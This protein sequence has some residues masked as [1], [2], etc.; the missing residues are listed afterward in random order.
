VTAD[1]LSGDPLAVALAL[2]EIG[3][4]VLP[5]HTPLPD[6]PCTC[7]RG[8]A[9]ADVGK[10]PRLRSGVHGAT[11]D[12]QL[13][14]GWFAHWPTSNV[15][16][17]CRDRLVVI[18]VDGPDEV[19]ALR[20]LCAGRQLGGLR[21]RTGRPDGWHI[22]FD[23]PGG[24]LCTRVADSL[25]RSGQSYVVAPPSIHASGSQY[26]FVGGTLEQPPPWLVDELRPAPSAVPTTTTNGRSASLVRTVVEPNDAHGHILRRVLGASSVDELDRISRHPLEGFHNPVGYG[27]SVLETACHRIRNAAE[28][29]RHSVVNKSA[30]I[31]GGYL[32]ATGLD[33]HEVM[34]ALQ[35]AAEDSGL[36]SEADKAQTERSILRGLEAGAEHPRPIPERVA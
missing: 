12:A 32:A 11:C 23:H 17:A 36:V 7:Q 16:A 35:A 30:Y 22:W 19:T 2:A 6:G 18:D 15:G 13:I 14:R 8:P 20:K 31:V 27:S 33:P 3:V 26:A 21:I 25:V 4:A 34:D 28:G 9:C 5:V 10:H 24:A 29:E 1:L